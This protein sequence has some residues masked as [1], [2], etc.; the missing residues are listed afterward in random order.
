MKRNNFD[1]T[2][3]GA[4]RVGLPLALSFESRGLSVAIK[5]INL[6]I[7]ISIKQK[8][9]PFKEKGMQDLLKKS[10]IVC[11]T[12][13][14]PISNYYLITV[15]TPLQQNIE[16]DLSQITKVIDGLINSKNISGNTIIL[17]STIAPN[18]M[19][20]ISSYINQ[21]T[22]LVCGKNYFL[23]Y[24]PE[25]IVEGDAI[26]EL[27]NLPQIIGVND[28][29]TW[30]KSKKLF[31][32]LL[33]K[34]KIL[35]GTWAEAELSKLFSNIYRYINFAI[36]NYFLMIA[37]HFN[38]EPFALFDLMN[39][40]YDRNKG[41]KSPGL[42]AGTCLRKDYGMINENFPQTDLILQAHKINE[43]MPMF[44][45]NL[46]K[47]E[48]IT[49][50]RIGILGYVFKKDT[51]DTRDSLSPKIY[52]YLTKLVPKIINISD[53][54]LLKGFYNDK[55][56][57]LTFKNLNEKELIKNSDVIIIAVNHSK[58]PDLLKKINLKKKIII[59]PWRVL[60]KKLI[61]NYVKG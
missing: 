18:T 1:I 55:E 11:F 37:N 7:I 23:S 27:T 28:K 30:F 15:G 45:I 42:T 51:D 56:N 38:V 44:I 5:D 40:E 61:N 6:K 16:T 3:I 52:R 2:V 26:K 22:G 20:F 50:K 4:G 57:Q 32:Y 49:N 24:C 25:R 59:D 9:S 19:R 29:K 53:Y 33:P 36:P 47:P 46:L 8:K 43:F 58:Y 35:K 54:N 41:L 13:K 39:F 31:E 60:S 17:R 48:K 21:K 34:N 12:D 14:Y 10:K